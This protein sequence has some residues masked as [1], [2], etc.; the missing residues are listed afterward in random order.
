MRNA[1]RNCAPD[2]RC[3][4]PIASAA[5][6]GGIVGCV[7]RPKIRSGLVESC[8]SSKSSACPLVP[9]SSAAD[10]APVRNG[11]GRERCRVG[12][13]VAAA[14]VIAQDR[15]GGAGRAGEHDAE[16]V[17]H[18]ALGERDRVGR[19]IRPAGTG[20]EI[21]DRARGAHLF[22]HAILRGAFYFAFA[23]MP[24]ARCRREKR[25]H[26]HGIVYRD[27]KTEHQAGVI[28]GSAHR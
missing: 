19:K 9:F 11:S 28:P 23:Q 7:S 22:G 20:D 14:S 10:A 12:G 8:V 25:V 3:R 15:A 1:S 4:S 16:A 18:A 17:D 27:L 26:E 6:S 21:D 24:D 2:A 13:F 5:A